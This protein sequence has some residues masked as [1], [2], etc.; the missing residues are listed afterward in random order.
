[1][2]SER[3]KSVEYK[4]KWCQFEGI[5]QREGGGK[6]NGELELTS[7][8]F[9]QLALGETLGSVHDGKRV[10]S[11]RLAWVK[12]EDVDEVVRERWERRRAHRGRW[13]KRKSEQALVLGERIAASSSKT[14]GF[15][16]LER[17]WNT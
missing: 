6:E 14:N 5:G 15:S 10:S 2:V 8:D 17:R 3:L 16:D 4:G 11:I 1:M 13:G 9:L 12:R 7:G